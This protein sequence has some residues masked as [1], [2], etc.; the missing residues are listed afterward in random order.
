MILLLSNWIHFNSQMYPLKKKSELSINF[1]SSLLGA[2]IRNQLR[3]SYLIIT[4]DN[5]YYY[6]YF[7]YCKIINIMRYTTIQSAYS[8]CLMSWYIGCVCWCCC[9]YIYEAMNECSR[10]VLVPT[11]CFMLFFFLIWDNNKLIKVKLD[12]WCKIFLNKIILSHN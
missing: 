3:K 7:S 10:S 5:H 1:Y 4:L 6:H 11:W 12:F 8:C 9:C 2:A